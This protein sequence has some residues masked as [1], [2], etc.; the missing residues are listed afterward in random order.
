MRDL[1]AR[2][3]GFI[4]INQVV[5]SSNILYL[6]QAS[7]QTSYKNISILS[8]LCQSLLISPFFSA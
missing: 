6:S 5:S 1:S 3:A 8:G 4:I 7:G 2:T